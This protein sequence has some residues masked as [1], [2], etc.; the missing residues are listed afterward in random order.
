MPVKHSPP[1]NNKRSQRN[2]AFLT[3][4]ARAPLDHTP[5]VHQ[6]SENLDR[7]P[8]SRRRGPRRRLGEAE[9]EEWEE[10]V[11]K[12]DFEENKVEAAPKAS[13]APNLALSNKPLIPQAEP[14]FSKIMQKLNQ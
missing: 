4:T 12:E 1:A 9:D 8:P 10:S 3:P 13:G 11:E 14:N 7:G 2:Q 5:S 6:L